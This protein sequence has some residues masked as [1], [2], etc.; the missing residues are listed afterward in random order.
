MQ[1]GLPWAQKPIRGF[2]FDPTTSLAQ[3]L[4]WLAPCWEYTGNTLID[5]VSGNSLTNGAGPVSPTLGTWAPTGSQ[6]GSSCGGIEFTGSEATAGLAV[7]KA[8]QLNYPL[9]MMVALQRIGTP[10]SGC[11]L[12]AFSATGGYIGLNT[13]TTNTDIRLEVINNTT[14]ASTNT[15]FINSLG[16]DAVLAI[17][18][19]TANY[20]LWANGALFQTV[21][22]AISNCGWG[23]TPYLCLGANNVADTPNYLIYWAALWNRSLAASEYEQLNT[24]NSIGKLFSPMVGVDELAG[25]QSRRR[26]PWHL[27]FNQPASAA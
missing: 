6:Y 9:T 1:A 10:S 24:V 18:V 5:V 20:S 26:I 17:N 21:T 4:V 15:T 25:A 11:P 3:G 16:V 8:L 22:A 23:G 2:C 7:P 27:F 14:G 13:A 12:F 19:T